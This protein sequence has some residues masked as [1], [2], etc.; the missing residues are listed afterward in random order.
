VDEI[1]ETLVRPMIVRRQAEQFTCAK[2]G[3]QDHARSVGNEDSFVD[4]MDQT[5]VELAVA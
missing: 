2:V 5:V 1:A 3:A 4:Q